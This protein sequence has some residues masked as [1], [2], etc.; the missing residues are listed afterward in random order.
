MV[1]LNIV[2]ILLSLRPYGSRDFGF[3][4]TGFSSSRFGE[5][6]RFG[7]CFREFGRNETAWFHQPKKNKPR[8]RA[9][10]WKISL[11]TERSHRPRLVWQKLTR[12]RCW[13]LPF[14][15]VVRRFRRVSVSTRKQL[16][17]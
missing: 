16:Y 2:I 8:P 6:G 9:F 10:L 7:F 17:F 5:P 1:I 15:P 13:L 12:P 14:H 4:S 3:H 11:H